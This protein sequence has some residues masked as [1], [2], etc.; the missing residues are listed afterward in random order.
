MPSGNQDLDPVGEVW[1]GGAQWA[2]GD[3]DSDDHGDGHDHGDEIYDDEYD[4]TEMV[5][6]VQILT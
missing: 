4:D 5:T 1:E 3:G 6:V 2:G